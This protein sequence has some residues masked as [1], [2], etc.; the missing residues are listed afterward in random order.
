MP[1]VTYVLPPQQKKCNI[2][3]DEVE[4]IC[5]FGTVEFPFQNEQVFVVFN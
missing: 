5:I 1:S 4:D 2:L 3:K